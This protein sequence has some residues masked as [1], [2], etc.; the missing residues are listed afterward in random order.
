M[1]GYENPGKP[2]PRIEALIY[3]GKNLLEKKLK[4]MN[5]YSNALKITL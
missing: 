2:I 4:V 5:T 1:C 3:S